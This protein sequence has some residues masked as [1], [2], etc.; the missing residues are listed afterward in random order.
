MKKYLYLLLLLLV[1]MLWS[2]GEETH[3]FNL[4]VITE[5]TQY[6]E[7]VPTL[8]KYRIHVIGENKLS[9]PPDFSIVDKVNRFRTGDTV[10]FYKV[11]K[12]SNGTTEVVNDTIQESLE[13]KFDD[14]VEFPEWD[15]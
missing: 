10:Y 13:I 12:R 14:D 4:F 2:C 15:D 6:S 8:A 5:I 3:E 11:S 1:P 7:E 9:K